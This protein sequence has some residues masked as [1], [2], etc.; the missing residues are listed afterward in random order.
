MSKSVS[1]NSKCA[2]YK[3]VIRPIV[4]YGSESWC[5]TQKEE[6]SLLTFERNVLRTI[7]GPVFD[8]NRW[9]RRFNHELTQ[10]YGVPDI[11]R[12]M[13][14]SRL[15]SLCHVQRLKDNRV[16]KKLMKTRPEGKRSAGRPKSRWIDAAFSNLRTV[17]V[18]LGDVGCE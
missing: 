11:I 10:L 18:K 8:Q 7:F 16:P 5:M 17:G 14:V 3:S 13:K 9:R 2:L 1:R 6:Q 15:R 12:T 4:T